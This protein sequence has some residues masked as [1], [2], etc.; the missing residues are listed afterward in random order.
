MDAGALGG[1]ELL[2]VLAALANPIRLDPRPA[3]GRT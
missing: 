1:E 3:G 2:G